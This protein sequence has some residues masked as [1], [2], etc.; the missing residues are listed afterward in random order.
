[1]NP[2]IRVTVPAVIT[3]V[4][5]FKAFVED[6][7]KQVEPKLGERPSKCFYSPELQSLVPEA[8][9]TDTIQ[10]LM[11]PL[12]LLSHRQILIGGKKST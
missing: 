7:A 1:M 5:A 8:L 6:M 3:T 12:S 10:F 11:V 4:D 2:G 9:D